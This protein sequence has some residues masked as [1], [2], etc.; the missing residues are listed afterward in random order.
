EHLQH[1]PEDVPARRQLIRLYGS[2]G[3]LDRANAQTE[4]LADM[5]PRDSPVPSVELGHALELA[6]HFDDALA[7]YD[8]AAQ[9]APHDALGPRTG[10]ERAAHWGQLEIAEPRLE[11]AVRRDAKDASSWHLLGV[12]RLG[13]GQL[14]AA[15]RAYATGLQVD[16]NSLENRLGLATVALRTNRPEIALA[17]YDALLEARPKFTAAL[18]GRSWS[19]ILLGQWDA[20]EAALARAEALGADPKTLERQRGAIRDRTGRNP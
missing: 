3:R 19:L 17:Q 11:E 13:L 15:Q 2:V 5:L 6:H 18:L 4:R 1:E 14:Q 8:R 7:A 12:V 20:A 10:G 16:P 9:I